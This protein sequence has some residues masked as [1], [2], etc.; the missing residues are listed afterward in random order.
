MKHKHSFRL[1]MLSG[2]LLFFVVG[3]G[4]SNSKTSTTTSKSSYKS[5]HVHTYSKEWTYDDNYHWHASTC[6]HTGLKNDYGPHTFSNDWV[7]EKQP[8]EYSKGKKYKECDVCGYKQYQDIDLLPHTHKKGNP[9][10]ENRVEAQCEID[11]HYDLVYYCIECGVEISREQKTIP[12]KGHTLVHHDGKNPTCEEHGY[13]PYDTCMYCSYTTYEDLSPTGHDFGEPTYEW[14]SSYSYCTAKRVCK[15]NAQHVEYEMKFSSHETITE[16]TYEHQ[17]LERYTVHFDN[18]EF[19]SQVHDEIIPQKDML[20]YYKYSDG[21]EVRADSQEIYGD[22]VIPEVYDNL[23]VTTV[24]SFFGCDNIESVV[25]PNSVTTINSNAFQSC[26]S[27][28]SITIGNNVDYIGSYAFSGGFIINL[29]GL[30][31]TRIPLVELRLRRYNSRLLPLLCLCESLL[32][33]VY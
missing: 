33:Q 25:I 3:C 28:S 14:S 13:K 30:H 22:I 7:I 8:T 20:K 23:P 9:T 19:S 18:P 5:V 6:V 17:G 10:E 32:R 29:E 16:A 1:Y 11:G 27:L 15:N 31:C 24:G 2:L 21:Y 26:S 4:N 12:A